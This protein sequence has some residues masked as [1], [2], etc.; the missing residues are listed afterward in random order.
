MSVIVSGITAIL[1]PM[2]ACGDSDDNT[3]TPSG[4]TTGSADQ[5]DWRAVDA[6]GLLPEEDVVAYLGETDAPSSRTDEHGRPTCNWTGSGTDRI[7]LTVW[8]PPAPDVIAD[9]SKRTLD[10]GDKTGYVTTETGSSCLLEVDAGPA[11]LSMQ[12]YASGTAPGDD[13]CQL[14]GGSLA[15]AVD[16]LGW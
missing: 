16:T 4:A 2:T 3:R 11:F 8:E 1:L 9:P 5:S 14:V 13:V 7:R 10:V 6:C 12:V 15:N